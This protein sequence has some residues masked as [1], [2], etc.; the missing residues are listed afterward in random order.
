MKR[1]R[2][3][4]ET[5]LDVRKKLEDEAL[6][7]LAS[8]QR[9][10]AIALQRK[11]DLLNEIASAYRRLE[12]FGDSRSSS[13]GVEP[14]RLERDFIAGS[15]ARVVQADQAILRAHR[16]VERAM[17]GYLNARR[18]TRTIEILREK[19]LE[20]YKKDRNA[21]ENK[22]QSELTVMRHRLRGTLTGSWD[23]GS[24]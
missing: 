13:E 17:R 22:E 15:K 12:A 23:G 21:A 3:R 14:F 24:S 18:S 11:E 9:D 5:V 19:D 10:R 16:A 6:K 20:A 7:V 8:T 4:F 1:F 2:F